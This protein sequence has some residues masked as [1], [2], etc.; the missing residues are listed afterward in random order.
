[1][2]KRLF[3]VFFNGCE[4]LS[5]SGPQQAFH[6]ANQFG[7]DYEIHHCG[8]EPEAVTEQGLRVTGLEPLPEATSGDRIFISGYTVGHAFPS[9]EVVRWLKRVADR[10]PT[11]VSVC[12]GAFFLGMAG[13]LDGRPCTTHWKRYDL[14][15]KTFPQAVVLKERLFVE[16]GNLLTSGGGASSI[17]MALH[18]IEK[19]YGPLV[20]ARVAREMVVYFRRDADTPQTSVYLDYRS[21]LNPSIHTLQDA[22]SNQPKDDRGL[23]AW[24]KEVGMSPRNLTRAFRQATG[25]SIAEY[26]TKIR[27]ERAKG[28]LN[29]PDLTVEAVA[30]LCGF[31]DGRQ[32]RRLWRQNFGTSPKAPGTGLPPG[33]PAVSTP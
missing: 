19:D 1:M 30:A 18:L 4:G 9:A 23:A 27:L 5:F 33:Q 20:T 31:S 12:S 15:Q 2:H 3:F 25:I 29:S 21:H 16:D 26:R 11:M 17:D 13:L 32:L 24:A 6:E 10:G 22:L 8:F 28:L 7:A 14:L